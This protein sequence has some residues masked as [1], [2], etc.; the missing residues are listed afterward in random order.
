MSTSDSVAPSAEAAKWND[1]KERFFAEAPVTLGPYFS[2]ILKRTP[3]RLLH[4]LSYYKFAAKMIGPGK[5]VLDVGS[6]EGIG[7]LVLA[8]HAAKCVGADIDA[9]AIKTAT[10]TLA[11]PTLSFTCADV[12]QEPIGAFDAV[13]CFDV[14]E[15]IYQDHELQFV[16]A[17]CRNIEGHGIAVIGTPNITADQYASAH[18][19][20][21]HVNLYSGERLRAL[22]QERFRHVFLFSANDEVVHTGFLAMAHYLIALCAGPKDR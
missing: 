20:A 19:R 9:D 5:R 22:C 21:G 12:L 6:S 18:S 15:H 14:I 13:T 8:E 2:F 17:L 16:D 1:T 11:S 7:T 4:L 3:R 10:S